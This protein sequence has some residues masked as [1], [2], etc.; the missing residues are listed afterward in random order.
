MF[1]WQVF[2]QQMV[3]WQ[4]FRTYQ[5]F[6]RT[7]GR[8]PRYN[9][10]LRARLAR[11]G[12]ER[13]FQ[14]EDNL[15]RQNKLAT[16]IEFLN[17]QYQDYGKYVRNVERLQPVFDKAW[18]VLVD[19]HVLRPF[20]T[21]EFICNPESAFQHTDEREQAEKVVESAELAVKSVQNAIAD[22]SRSILS[23]EEPRQLL[24]AAQS[25]LDEAI[26]SLE[27]I[28]RRNDLVNEFFAKTAIS[29]L[30]DGK[31]TKTYQGEKGHAEHCEI[32]IRWILKQISLI[33]LEING[34]NIAKQLS[35]GV[36]GGWGRKRNRTFELDKE[37]LSNGHRQDGEKTQTSP[38]GTRVSTTKDQE[39]KL[40]RSR[41]DSFNRGRPS[42]RPKYN[43]SS[44]I[45]LLDKTSQAANS[46]SIIQAF[47]THLPTSQN[48]AALN[49][50]TNAPLKPS[51]DE[52]SRVMKRERR[53]GK[54][55]NHSTPPSSLRQSTRTRRP[56]ERFQ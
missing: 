14:L 30:V 23:Q 15:D 29:Q 7:Q 32:L 39:S 18:Q 26:K 8:F 17:Y 20:E 44:S 3:V 49:T 37:Y 45:F 47:P 46:A 16:W 50:Q 4:A 11:Y 40:K 9:Q 31:M 54:F 41:D 28:E 42:K 10:R 51:E 52:K 48:S 19:A 43:G 53:G 56:P 21:Q 1:G 33:E 36:R 6:T 55:A 5:Q 27:L 12:F 2:R 24:A 38:R 35:T 22:P 25:R 34:A 13:P